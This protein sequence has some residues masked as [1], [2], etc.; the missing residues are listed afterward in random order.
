MRV[1]HL[2][3]V[4]NLWPRDIHALWVTGARPD[5]ASAG[6]GHAL[7]MGLLLEPLIGLRERIPGDDQVTLARRARFD[8]F[9]Q[10]ANVDVVVLQAPELV[11]EPGHRPGPVHRLAD[12]Q[13]LGRELDLVQ[14][15]RP[16]CGE[17][18]VAGGVVLLVLRRVSQ[19]QGDSGY[20]REDHN[21]RDDELLAP[22]G[23]PDGALLRRCGRLSLLRRL[24]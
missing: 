14:G 5:E 17:G 15:L 16:D 8:A 19:P 23:L 21:A 6:T 4:R 18:V 1:V 13:R 24:V 9:R 10:V 22:H 12:R 20:D 3:L 2:D 11:M 7:V